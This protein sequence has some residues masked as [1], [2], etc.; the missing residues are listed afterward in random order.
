MPPLSGLEIFRRRWF[1]FPHQ[2]GRAEIFFRLVQEHLNLTCNALFLLR[3][4]RE[5]KAQ[6]QAVALRYVKPAT[7]SPGKDIGQQR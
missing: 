5:D 6:Q 2:N 3:Q 1:E 7:V 4:E